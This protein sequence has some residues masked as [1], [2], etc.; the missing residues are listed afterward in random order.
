[1]NRYIV[2]DYEGIVDPPRI[3]FCIYAASPN[4]AYKKLAKFLQARGRSESI[5]ELVEKLKRMDDLEILEAPV[6]GD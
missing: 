3:G 1:M 6:I 5:P 4:D 2:L